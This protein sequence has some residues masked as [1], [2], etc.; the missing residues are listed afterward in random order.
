MYWYQTDHAGMPHSLTDIRGRVVYRCTFTA[1]G[2]L[3]DEAFYT[4]ERTG[5][6]LINVRNPLR[7]QGQY[8]DDESGLFYNL[9]RYYDPTTGR[10]ITPDPVGLMG[11]LNPY[12]YVGGNPV[13]WVDPLGL[14]KKDNTGFENSAKGANEPALPDTGDVTYH[15]KSKQNKQIEQLRNGEDITVS[16]VEEARMILDSMPELKPGGGGD[17]I[18]GTFD[19][20]GTYRGDLIN[21]ADPSNTVEVHTSGPAKHRYNAHYN[22]TLLTDLSIRLKPAIII[23]GD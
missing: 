8:E 11:G 1:Y 16:S 18:P 12:V 13:G 17:Y 3:L 22:L 7:F 15:N 23:K 4:D 6:P 14:F 21:K 2:K 5:N 20:P 19:P 9:N 10:Y